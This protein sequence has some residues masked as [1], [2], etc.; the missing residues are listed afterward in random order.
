M[1]L[2]YAGKRPRRLARWLWLEVTPHEIEAAMAIGWPALKEV[3]IAGWRVFTGL[4]AVGRVNSCWPL[5]FD[6][7]DLSAAIDEVEHHY[8][9]H[10]LA[11]QFKCI[12]DGAEP[13]MLPEQLIARGYKVVSHVAVMICPQ[14]LP[15]PNQAVVVRSRVSDAFVDVVTETSPTPIDGKER[16][17]ILHRVPVPS[18]FGEISVEGEVAAVGLATFTGDSAGIAAMRTKPAYRQRG[19]ARA[20]LRA[21]SAQAFD[22]GANH[23]WLQVETSNMAASQLYRSEGFETLYH[24]QTWRLA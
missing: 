24:Y 15:K 19:L 8:R 11:P 2:I 13:A 23:L 3:N 17:D 20:I 9:A 7:S 4:G 12:E 18:A 6:G 21:V 1:A 16:G 10:K 22:A 5:A 14:R